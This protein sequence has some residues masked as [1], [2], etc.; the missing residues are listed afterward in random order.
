MSLCV[1][2]VSSDPW[3]LTVTMAGPETPNG[4]VVRWLEASDWDGDE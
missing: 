4:K 2:H 1:D 3:R